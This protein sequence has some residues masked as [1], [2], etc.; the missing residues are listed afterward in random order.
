MA[1]AVEVVL[2]HGIVLPCEVGGFPRPS[3]TW[4][5]EGVPVATGE[6]T[7]AFYWLKC[8]LLSTMYVHSLLGIDELVTA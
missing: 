3:I 7:V 1:E 2:H 8:S 4:Q 6:R 5:R